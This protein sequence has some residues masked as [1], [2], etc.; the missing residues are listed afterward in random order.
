MEYKFILIIKVIHLFLSRGLCNR[1]QT[2]FFYYTKIKKYNKTLGTNL[3]SFT[4]FSQH[5]C[6]N[7]SFILIY[8]NYFC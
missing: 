2:I 4:R 8:C 1:L 5:N 7:F 3:S 6:S